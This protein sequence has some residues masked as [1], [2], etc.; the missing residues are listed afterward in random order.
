[1]T[2]EGRESGAIFNE[3]SSG[4]DADTYGL[5][6][7]EANSNRGAGWWVNLRRR[8]HKVVRLFKDSIYGSPQASFEQARAYRDAVITALPPP[9]NHEQA[10]LLRRN[11]QSGISGVRRIETAGGDAWQA[12]LTTR[13]GQKRETFSVAKYGDEAAKSMA[14]AQR[15]RWLRGLPVKH[16]AY[17]QHAEEVTRQN[18][19]HQLTPAT[20]VLPEIHITDEEIVASLSEI[21]ARFDALRPLRLR[22]RIRSYAAGRLSVSVSDAGQPAQRKLVQVNVTAR[23]PEEMIRVVIGHLKETIA[24]LYNEN[25]ACWFMETH[26]NAHLAT[27]RFNP[28]EGFNLLVLVPTALVDKA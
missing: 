27:D 18:F 28:S 26:G 8:G 17:A 15:S 23:S 5:L 3:A 2:L 21:N 9:T 4:D 1:M 22:V 19:T 16:L 20:D 13:E 6:R 14:I 11:N 12:T 10:V 25:V 24:D 7:E